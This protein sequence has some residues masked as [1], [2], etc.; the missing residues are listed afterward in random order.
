MLVG[1]LSLMVLM[2]V[3]N[4]QGLVEYGREVVPVEVKAGNTASRSLN[5]FIE[6][7]HPEIAYKL[8]SSRNGRSD[9]KWTL[10]H[11]SVI[12]L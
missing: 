9:E 1:L 11:Y 12:F 8:I 3:I 4:G 6:K 10:P 2:M 7:Y 5:R